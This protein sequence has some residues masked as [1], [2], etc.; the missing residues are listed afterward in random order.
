MNDKTFEIGR[1]YYGFGYGSYSG[2][3][4]ACVETVRYKGIVTLACTSSSCDTPYHFYAFEQVSFG[5]SYGG[6]DIPSLKQ[7][8][9]T[10]LTRDELVEYLRNDKKTEFA[11]SVAKR[12]REE[13][14]SLSEPE[15]AAHSNV[16]RA[17]EIVRDRRY[18]A[19]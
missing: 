11:E 10:V 2:S 14:E 9:E 16:D 13:L 4:Q 12:I 15:R 1:L 8:Q 7:V 19:G 5:G 6:F 17:I 3:S 18:R